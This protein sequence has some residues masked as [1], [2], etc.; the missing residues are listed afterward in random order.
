MSLSPS[1]ADPDGP[2]SAD[3]T[4]GVH[5]GA[6]AGG[7]PHQAGSE[8]P[9]P[10]KICDASSGSMLHAAAGCCRCCCCDDAVA[11]SNP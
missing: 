4:N 8:P 7:A 2:A 1:A 11:I 6:N 5:G 3:G 9:A 10:C